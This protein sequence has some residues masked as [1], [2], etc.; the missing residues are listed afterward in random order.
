MA[1]RV[2]YKHQIELTDGPQ[3]IEVRGPGAQILDFQIQHGRLTI[4][5]MENYRSDDDPAE[6]RVQVLGTGSEVEDGWAYV[7][8][9]QSGTF[10]WHLMEGAR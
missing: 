8:T 7:G 4:W 1:R 10:V 6:L 3:V 5:T 9:V 2:I